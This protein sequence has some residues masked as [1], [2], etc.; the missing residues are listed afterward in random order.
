MKMMPI[1][2]HRIMEV[3]VPEIFYANAVISKESNLSPGSL[4]TFLGSYVQQLQGLVLE[5]VPSLL[6]VQ[7]LFNYF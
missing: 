2:H 4:I 6:L 7:R 1:L 3:E 5:C